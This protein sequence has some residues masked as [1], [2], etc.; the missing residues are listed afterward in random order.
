MT[1]P[2]LPLPRGNQVDVQFHEHAADLGR[3]TCP[4]ELLGE[5]VAL[6][7]RPLEDPVAIPVHRERT[8]IGAD[9]VLH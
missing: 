2:T 8:A 7:W 4:C 9:N 3:I 5:R 1:A 6:G